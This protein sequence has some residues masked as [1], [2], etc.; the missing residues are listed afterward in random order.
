MKALILGSGFGTRLHPI[1]RITPKSFVDIK[2]K[3]LLAHIL[4]NLNQS[5]YIDEIYILYNYKF[6]SQFKDFLEHFPYQKKIELISDKEKNSQKM[7]GS[8]GSIHYFVELKNIQEDLLVLAGDSVFEF[9]IDNFIEF[10]QK[11]NKTSIAV[12]GGKTKKEIVGKYGV[13]KLKENKIVEFEEKPLD[14]KTNLVA[15]LCYI[16][17]NYDLHHLDKRTFKENAGELISYLV[18]YEE[19]YGWV[20]KEK[21]FDI[22]NHEDLEKARKEFLS[23]NKLFTFFNKKNNSKK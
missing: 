4:D 20:F 6:E 23:R 7:P 2:E 18:K 10:Y 14:P 12:Y 1:T 16:L 5:K 8:I 19:V 13:V 15:T 22:G 17:S 21:W 11:H 3:P 9:P